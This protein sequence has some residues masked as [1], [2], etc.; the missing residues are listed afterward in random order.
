MLNQLSIWEDD[1]NALILFYSLCL[2]W[3]MSFIK[4]NAEREST[5][6]LYKK[7]KVWYLFILDLSDST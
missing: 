6:V 7:I 1:E 3:F 4:V 5:Y 2:F